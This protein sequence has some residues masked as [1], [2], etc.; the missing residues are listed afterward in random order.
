MDTEIEIGKSYLFICNSETAVEAFSGEIINNFN[1]SQSDV[2]EYSPNDGVELLRKMIAG[3]SMKPHSSS[4]RFLKILDG[5]KLNNEQANSLLKTIEE[6]PNY[7]LIVIF[8]K[9]ASKILPT[10]KSRCTRV[11]SLVDQEGVGYSDFIS[12]L[13]CDF[14]SFFSKIKDIESDEI[15]DM[16]NLSLEH[17]KRSGMTVENVALYKKIA[18]VLMR[19]SSTNSNSRLALEEIFVWSR[20][21]KEK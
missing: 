16:L 11:Q 20:A 4:C 17:I 9:N 10:I 5:E 21:N 12:L 3:F 8:S 19:I 13:D 2:L 14:N 1:I 18:S 7:G 15:P 6:P